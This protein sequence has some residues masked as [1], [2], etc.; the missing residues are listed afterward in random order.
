M[1]LCRFKNFKTT[2][3]LSWTER[4]VKGIA[5]E[6]AEGWWP[7]SPMAGDECAGTDGVWAEEDGNAKEGGG[8]GDEVEAGGGRDDRLK[9]GGDDS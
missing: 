6:K 2:V 7:C 1:I 8:G 4:N 9:G 5:G 3:P